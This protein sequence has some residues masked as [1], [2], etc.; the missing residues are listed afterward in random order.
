MAKE[1]KSVRIESHIPEV[2]EEMHEV[3]EGWLAAVGLDAASVASN[4]APVDTGRLRNSISFATVKEHD[5]MNSHDGVP[6]SPADYALKAMPETDAVYIGTN[7]DYAPYHEY[8]TSKKVKAR[9]FIQFGMTAHKSQYKSLLQKAM[10][11][12]RKMGI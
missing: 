3:V 8:G 5:G 4:Y 2:T 10:E 12:G 7:V 9:H 1:V 11:T 6:A